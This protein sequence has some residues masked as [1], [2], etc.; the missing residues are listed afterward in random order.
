MQYLTTENITSKGENIALKNSIKNLE[1]NVAV[2]R[3]L[4]DIIS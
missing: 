4:F 3:V 2:N 1:K